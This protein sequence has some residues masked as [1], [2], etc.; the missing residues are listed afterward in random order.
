MPR[1]PAEHH[2][3]TP[4]AEGRWIRRGRVPLGILAVVLTISAIVIG[5]SV[6]GGPGANT[7][8]QASPTQVTQSWHLAWRSENAFPHKTSTTQTCRFAALL[9]ADGDHVRAEF[10]SPIVP[11]KGYV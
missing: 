8:V 3:A 5:T 9:T 2:A 11:G 1:R 6:L 4:P 7:G 10:S